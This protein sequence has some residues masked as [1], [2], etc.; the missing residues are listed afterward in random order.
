MLSL[1]SVL[2]FCHGIAK[3]GDCKVEFI[4]PSNW[5]YSVPNLLVIQHL[6]TLYLGG[7]DVR[8][9]S[10]IEWRLLKSVQENRDS[11]LGL[12]GD[13]RLQAA[14]RSTRAKHA[15]RWTVMQAGALQDK[16]GQLAIR[17]SRD[18]ISRLSQAARSSRE[19]P[20]FCKTWRF[21][22]LSHSSINT[23]FT[24]DCKRASRENFE[25][26]TL[27][28]NKIESPT[29]YTLESLQIPQLSSSPLSNPWD[30]NSLPLHC[31]ILERHYTKPGS[32]HHHH[33]E[34]VVWISGKQLGRNQSSLVDA[35]V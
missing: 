9:V 4:Q 13:S 14:R 7:F 5:L 31:Q 25:R 21:T 35:T 26:E 2:G 17:L 24:H 33:C 23:P 16:T 6:V 28:K 29:I 19:P 15:G 11:G 8:V 20:L 18:W 12:A 32:H 30:L 27:K 10:E 34:T 22:F 3:G 1:E